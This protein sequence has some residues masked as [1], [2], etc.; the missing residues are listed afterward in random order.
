MH[1]TGAAL[2]VVVVVVIVVVVVVIIRSPL[3]TLCR[4]ANGGKEYYHGLWRM[5]FLTVEL[6]RL[7]GALP[8]LLAFFHPV[9][10]MPG[11]A[12]RV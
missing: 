2:V 5:P 7:S 10:V 3:T 8:F 6:Q 12:R 9:F 1:R 11:R 4:T